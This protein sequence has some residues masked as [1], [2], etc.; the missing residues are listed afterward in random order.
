M[1]KK[2]GEHREYLKRHLFDATD[3]GVGSALLRLTP[4][5]RA[6][7]LRLFNDHIVT[8][9]GNVL[10]ENPNVPD[11]KVLA[12]EL[13]RVTNDKWRM[14]VKDLTCRVIADVSIVASTFLNYASVDNPETIRQIQV[15]VKQLSERVSLLEVAELHS[16]SHVDLS[17]Q[18]GKRSFRD[19][20]KAMLDVPISELWTTREAEASIQNIINSCDTERFHSEEVKDIRDK[21]LKKY[22]KSFLVDLRRLPVPDRGMNNATELALKPVTQLAISALIKFMFDNFEKRIADVLEQ[23]NELLGANFSMAGLVQDLSPDLDAK[24]REF[25]LEILNGERKRLFKSL[26]TTAAAV[27]SKWEKEARKKLR[28]VLDDKTNDYLGSVFDEAE[29]LPKKGPLSINQYRYDKVAANSYLAAGRVGKAL[30]HLSQKLME[31]ARKEFMMEMQAPFT[32]RFERM[33]EDDIKRYVDPDSLAKLKHKT[34]D[35]CDILVRLFGTYVSRFHEG[36]D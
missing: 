18:Y 21:Y 36:T 32:Q 17:I 3:S 29:A 4:E 8:L 10:L 1:K 19:Q 6:E 5:E 11:I 9:A 20:F 31:K 15:H 14:E 23:V 26:E 28:T 13:L 35:I 22:S 24:Q 30:V 16:S 27:K 25:V 7:K 12:K 33:D 2:K 34:A